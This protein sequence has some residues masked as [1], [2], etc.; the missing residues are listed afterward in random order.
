[1]VQSFEQKFLIKYQDLLVQSLAP[2]LE[3]LQKSQSTLSQIAQ[4]NPTD[5]KLQITLKQ[6]QQQI[7][8]IDTIL[9]ASSLDEIM[10]RIPNYLYLKQ[11]LE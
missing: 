11:A 2:Y 9:N 7:L 10:Q 5:E 6:T 4:E 1:M 8:A 3:N